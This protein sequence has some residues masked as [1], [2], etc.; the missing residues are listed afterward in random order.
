MSIYLITKQWGYQTCCPDEENTIGYFKPEN[1]ETIEFYKGPSFK[2]QK[3]EIDGLNTLIH[4]SNGLWGWK[5]VLDNEN[6]ITWI[7]VSNDKEIWA[8]FNEYYVDDG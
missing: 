7:C 6:K 5:K 3:Y 4:T 1:H 2:D 8:Q